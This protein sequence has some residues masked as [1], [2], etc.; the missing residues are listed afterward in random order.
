MRDGASMKAPAEDDTMKFVTQD[1]YEILNVAPGATNEDVKRAYRMVRQSFRPDSMAIHSLY[2]AEETEAI[3]AKID[4]AFQILSSPESARRY[5]KYHRAGRVGMKVPRDP[6]QFFDLV[7]DLSGKSPIEELAEQVTRARTQRLAMPPPREVEE[8][9]DGPQLPLKLARRPSEVRSRS[10]EVVTQAEVFIDSLEELPGAPAALPQAPVVPPPVAPAA[11]LLPPEAPATI[12]TPAGPALG[13]RAVEHQ[14]EPRTRLDATTRALPGADLPNVGAATTLATT[15]AVGV[16]RNAEPGR[17]WIRD[18]ISTRAVGPLVIEALPTAE[19]EALEMDC[20]GVTGEFLQQVRR[21]MEISLQDI[22]DRTKIG[23]S[24]LRY[25]EA[26][27]I[28]RLPA[29]VYLKG[30][31]NQICRL[32]HLPT[33]QIPERYLER[34]GL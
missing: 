30:Y 16:A 20:G 19:L 3:S 1:Y 33:P 10:L 5:D 14:P 26:D 32:L 13:R 2:S 34:H 28:D 31:L 11:S 29:R 25:I 18:T 15:P 23:I 27:N 6:D 7:H 9:S 22:A 21:G 4:E 24:A 17:R 8:P 12:S